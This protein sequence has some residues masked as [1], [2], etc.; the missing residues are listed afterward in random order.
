[1]KLES[2][3]W[4]LREPVEQIRRAY[5][6]DTSAH[7]FSTLY[8]WKQEMDLSLVLDPEFFAVRFGMRGENSWFF[9]YGRE[10]GVRAFLR[11][12]ME[13][14]RCRLSGGLVCRPAAG[15]PVGAG[16]FLTW[17]EERQDPATDRFIRTF[18]KLWG[19]AETG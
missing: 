17:G 6:S 5:G 8:L 7:A 1:M 16:V 14:G 19:T 2:I 4:H 18:L 10:D 9:P 13:E 11:E 15:L 3:D 12:R